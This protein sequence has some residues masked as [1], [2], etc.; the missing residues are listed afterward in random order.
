M[1]YFTVTPI[2]ENTSKL[3]IKQKEM[4]QNS[5]TLFSIV[6]IL[7]FYEVYPLNRIGNDSTLLLMLGMYIKYSYHFYI[8]IIFL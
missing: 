8:Y 5:N 4:C 3:L 2:A 6:Y 7:L 1:K